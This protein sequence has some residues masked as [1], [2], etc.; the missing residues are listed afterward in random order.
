M[1]QGHRN[2]NIAPQPSP[3]WPR[4]EH[5]RARCTLLGAIKFYSNVSRSHKP[6]EATL[7]AHRHHVRSLFF[8][9]YLTLGVFT[10]MPPEETFQLLCS[11]ALL[12]GFTAS[13]CARL[14]CSHVLCE[15]ISR[16]SE[17]RL[18]YSPFELRSSHLFSLKQ[19][20]SWNGEMIYAT[21]TMHRRLA[22]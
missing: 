8:A 5:R 9:F 17:S 3:R 4:K 1:R 2:N 13:L 7:R 12:W 18:F 15:N 10:F 21:L 16:Y 11:T 22:R 14:I 20:A 19:Q 6:V